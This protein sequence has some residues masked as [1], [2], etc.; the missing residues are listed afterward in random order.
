MP[1]QIGCMCVLHGVLD[2]RSRRRGR[3]GHNYAERNFLR[4]LMRHA[5]LRCSPSPVALAM[6]LSS[7]RALLQPSA[8]LAQLHRTLSPAARVRA[9]P[10]ASIAATTQV[11]DDVAATAGD[12][13]E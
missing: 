4:T 6:I 10:M 2:G 7:L 12:H 8:R 9:V 11:E 5:P 13:P 1:I 3:H